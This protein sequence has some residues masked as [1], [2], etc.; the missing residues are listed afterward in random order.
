V[1][2]H[3]GTRKTRGQDG[4]A[5]SFPVGTCTPTTC[6]FIP[7]HEESAVIQPDSWNNGKQSGSRPQNLGKAER[8]SR[9]WS[10]DYLPAMKMIR[11]GLHF[12]TLTVAGVTYWLASEGSLSTLL[13][14]KL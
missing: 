5:T 6:R 8:R 4:F 9:I 13:D 11:Y 2:P 12:A 7:A 14:L 10:C 3:D 1:T